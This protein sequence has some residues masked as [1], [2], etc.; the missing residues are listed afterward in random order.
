M[1]KTL[2]EVL[3]EQGFKL[4]PS[5]GGRWVVS[6]PFH[7]DDDSPSF[8]VYPN[9]TYFC[10]GAGC[11]VWGDAVKFLVEYKHITQ[12]EALEYVGIDYEFPKARKTK[13]VKLRNVLGTWKFLGEVTN[14]YHEY[15]KQ[16]PGAIN[17]LHGRGF[18]DETITRYRI[19][20]TDG[21]VLNLKFAE[22]Y[23][24]AVEAG[25]LTDKGFE[26]MSHRI[27]IPN[28]L[29]NGEVD[30]M[31]GRTVANSKVKYV[32]TRGN[33]P[34][35]GFF[36]VRKSPAILLVEGQMDWLMLRQWD[37]P[38]AAIASARLTKQ[39]EQLLEAKHVII[40]PDNDTEGIK[41]SKKLLERFPNSTLL[42]YS[43]FGFK[44]IAEF[45]QMKNAER[46]FA[47]IIREQCSW[48]FSYSNQTLLQW[49]KPLMREPLFQ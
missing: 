4:K 29:E 3:E 8:T 7:G 18:T 6:C 42:D 19:G 20:Y 25:I 35:H 44:D 31:T 10:F 21:Y 9:Q 16:T 12:E 39:N 47:D 32:H 26:T 34:I 11:G 24:L 38:A 33:K 41:A 37:W 1:A 17:Y 45:G 46:V 14:K 23:A 22:E 5:S 15:L 2:V 36:E 28:P 13:V 43:E 49:F 40:I 30:F 27:T 48:I